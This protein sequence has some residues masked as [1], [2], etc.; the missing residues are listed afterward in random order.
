MHTPPVL[1][2]KLSELMI[3]CQTMIWMT[4]MLT[5]LMG[6]SYFWLLALI[7]SFTAIYMTLLSRAGDKIHLEVSILF[8]LAIA[9]LLWDRHQTCR[10][11]F[12]LD[13]NRFSS[14]LGCLL[15]IT[16]VGIILLVHT[17]GNPTAPFIDLNGFNIQ[18]FVLLRILPFLAG[19]GIALITTR[20][21]T[22]W[23][24]WRELALV[25]FMGV[26][27]V[28]FKM[29]DLSPITARFSVFLLTSFGFDAT[30]SDNVFVLLPEGGVEV[31][32]GCSGAES[33]TYCLGISILCLIMFPSARKQVWPVPLVAM[34]IGFFVNA[35]RIVLLAIFVNTGNLEA[36]HYW[37]QGLGS[38]VFGLIAVL[39]FAIVYIGF[40]FSGRCFRKSLL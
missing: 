34:G 29:V 38:S 37:H 12:N 20:L 17:Q 33:I 4:P 8:G 9:S 13:S 7:A 36:F 11:T 27:S 16:A 6:K 24:F 14:T 39:I 2:E 15:I 1:S 3:K 30:L 40:F 31:Y 32:E 10:Q 5:A 19:L 35:M 26:P 22:V 23:I 28:L 21:T 25:F 18:V